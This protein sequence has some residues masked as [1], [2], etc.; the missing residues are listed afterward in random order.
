[1]YIAD[2][3]LMRCGRKH[4]CKHCAKGEGLLCEKTVPTLAHIRQ[5]MQEVLS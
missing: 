5:H 3:G 1:V 4:G 2:E